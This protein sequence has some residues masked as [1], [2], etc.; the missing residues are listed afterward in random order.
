MKSNRLSNQEIATI[1]AALTLYLG[2]AERT[3][4]IHDIATQNGEE[5]ALDYDEVLELIDTVGRI[6]EPEHYLIVVEGDV[7]PSLEGPFT[8]YG[9]VLQAARNHRADDPEMQD[10]LYFLETAN[11]ETEIGSF[12]SEEL[13]AQNWSERLEAMYDM[14]QKGIVPPTDQRDVY[15]AEQFDLLNAY[16]EWLEDLISNFADELDDIETEDPQGESGSI[17]WLDKRGVE[18]EFMPSTALFVLLAVAHAK[19]LD[20]EEHDELYGF[21]LHHGIKLDK[22]LK[23]FAVSAN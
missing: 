23:V 20:A 10:G 13:E 11:D 22:M 3:P 7:S 4:F 5:A 19:G 12:G 6:N 2:T 15:A 14:A 17:C 21:I 1:K 18:F 8:S 16:A 9:E